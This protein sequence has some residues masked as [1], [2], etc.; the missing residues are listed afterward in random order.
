MHTRRNIEH[1]EL[2]T[3]AAEHRSSLNNIESQ[4][5]DINTKVEDAS[6][7][8]NAKVDALSSSINA[9]R[10]MVTTM[11]GVG[12][13]IIRFMNAFPSEMRSM[14]QNILHVD[15]QNYLLLLDLQQKFAPNPTGLLNSNIEFEDAMGEVR[16][17]PY[18]YFRHWEVWCSRPD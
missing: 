2:L 17:L 12:Q 11:T 4:I 16:T 1:S 14:L 9:T 7:A 13:Q 6:V 5:K 18:E 15:R 8:S 10:T 3:K